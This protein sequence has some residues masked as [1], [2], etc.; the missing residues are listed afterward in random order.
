MK[1][2]LAGVIAMMMVLLVG[3]TVFASPS[4]DKDSAN[5]E[6]LQAEVGS[7]SGATAV[8]PDGNGVAVGITAVD[9]IDIVES[10]KT[11]AT[12]VA[13][14]V[15]E[16]ATANVLGIVDVQSGI[17]EGYISIDVTFQ[18][19][20]IKVGDKVIVLHQKENGV[21]EIL[22]SKVK[23][24]GQV[25]ATFTSFSPVAIFRVEEEK[26]SEETPG[27]NN[28]GTGTEGTQGTGTT[29]TEGSGTQGTGTEGTG[30][31]AGAGTGIGTGTEGAGTEGTGTGATG[32]EGSTANTEVTSK[33]NTKSTTSTDLLSPI[34]GDLW[35]PA[36]VFVGLICGAGIILL[37]RKV[38]TR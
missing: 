34:T 23:K 4:V 38:I 3:T 10:A 37:G 13:A 2:R 5:E 24:D 8:T 28:Q 1:K 22:A 32:S 27:T 25:T 17:P 26:Q 20:G 31:G 9:S 16:G 30:T 33:E 7:V 29:G 19:S 6:I 11:R 12:V 35:I 15:A 14:K 36:I 18:V 21:W